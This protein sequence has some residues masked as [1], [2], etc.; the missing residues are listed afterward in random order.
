M[1]SKKCQI[2]TAMNPCEVVHCR[3]FLICSLVFGFV[4]QV[5]IDEGEEALLS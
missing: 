1:I 5:I 4:N 3:L 2:K